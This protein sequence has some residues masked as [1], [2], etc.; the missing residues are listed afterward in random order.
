M[1]DG[2][3]DIP[4]EVQDLFDEY[5]SDV[6]DDERL[7]LLEEHLL[8]DE[9]LARA[10]AT[11]FHLHTELRF[12]IRAG[13]AAGEAV[14]RITG[15]QRRPH[16]A[17]R[18]AMAGLIALSLVGLAALGVWGWH[19]RVTDRPPLTIAPKPYPRVDVEDGLA[20]VV[21]LDAVRWFETDPSRPA[22]GDV[23]APGRFRFRS[24]RV[25]LTMFNG[26][27]MVAEGP[28]DLDL[29]S[30]ERVFC[31][32][33][34]LRTRVPRDA[35]GF[36]VSSPASAVLDLGTEFGLN[37]GSDGA[38]Q[39]KV[40]Q[41]RAEAVVRSGSGSDVQERSRLL[42]P[43]GAFDVDPSAGQIRPA[44][45]PQGFA[46]P[47]DLDAP[48]LALDPSYP[49]AVLA[50]GPWSYW[51]FESMEQ[52]AVANEIA[53]RPPLLARGPVRLTDPPPA[54][55]AGANR[56]AL[57]TAD[58]VVKYFEMEG[59]WQPAPEPGRAAELW[60]LSEAIDHASLISL[61]GEKDTN[62]HTFFLEL[63]SRNRHTL[64]PP[65][66]VRF[67]DRWPA[68]TDGGCN[69]YSEHHYTPYR[70]HHV[71]GQ[72][73]GGRME[74]FLDGKPARSLSENLEHPTQPSQVLLGR[75]STIPLSD[76]IHSRAFVGQI[77]E[78]AL[79][80][81]PLSA[82]EIENHYKLGS[83]EGREQS[84]RRD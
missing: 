72:M 66:I 29:V 77:D 4:S 60:F 13:R 15:Q 82:E 37:V 5:C 52:N 28:A 32:Q 6:I 34:R 46:A 8:G 9:K 26:V 24:G 19:R 53:G 74:L 40:F 67:L 33:G 48:P 41:G 51:R 63:T 75:L 58:Q 71:V 56:S 42:G 84:P 62:H 2:R 79:Y 49:R 17:A 83:R 70:W 38:A 68:G 55:S 11:Y 50:S 43:A 10:F 64:H 57:F 25:T 12:A 69:I 27:V 7:R 81:R 20:V 30:T 73:N 16:R 21:R 18:R 59:S 45:N 65:A 47:S 76:Y 61:V 23:L 22:E 14:A 39:V 78:V 31:R 35:H 3:P 44:R 1:M 36:V 54:G 80:E